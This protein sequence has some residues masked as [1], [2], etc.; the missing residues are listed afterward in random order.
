VAF[1]ILNVGFGGIFKVW[2]VGVSV[3]QITRD[4]I[5]II[6]ID[7]IVIFDHIKDLYID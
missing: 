7:I 5:E 1:N 4:Q 3:E 2:E 6:H